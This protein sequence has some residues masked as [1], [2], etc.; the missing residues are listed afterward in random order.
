MQHKWVQQGPQWQGSR[1]TSTF[2]VAGM[3]FKSCSC[4]LKPAMHD[5]VLPSGSICPFQTFIVTIVLLLLPNIYIVSNIP[6]I[7]FTTCHA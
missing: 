1:A 3:R 2:S 4:L 7:Y 5:L 6:N